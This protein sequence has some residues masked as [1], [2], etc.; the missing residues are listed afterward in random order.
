MQ[1]VGQADAA[2]AEEAAPAVAPATAA[3][4]DGAANLSASGSGFKLFVARRKESLVNMVRRSS[5]NSS[6]ENTPASS[7]LFG[8]KPS[9]E[10]ALAVADAEATLL[11]QGPV[12]VME[13]KKVGAGF[14]VFVSLTR[15][16]V[17]TMTFALTT[18]CFK[19]ADGTARVALRD[20]TAVMAGAEGFEHG[21][22]LVTNG[23]KTVLLGAE[24]AE[25]AHEWMLALAAACVAFGGSLGVLGHSLRVRL[26]AASVERYTGGILKREEI[27]EE[28][29]YRK[30]GLLV[31]QGKAGV[32][33]QWDGGSLLPAKGANYGK[34][35]FDGLVLTWH[36]PRGA[37]VGFEKKTKKKKK[38]NPKK[39]EGS[40]TSSPALTRT[41]ETATEAVVPPPP[42]FEDEPA[43]AFLFCPND[44]TYYWFDLATKEICKTDP[45]NWKWSRHFLTK[46][47]GIG[48][49]ISEGS[50]PEH[51]VMLLQMMRFCRVG[52]AQ[53]LAAT[54]EPEKDK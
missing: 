4:A 36:A 32:T 54:A 44:K 37:A 15:G 18:A 20:V 5:S 52:W 42:E 13:R 25:G 14:F 3:V 8:R 40:S 2:A 1:Q 19:C 22:S 11:K 12:T 7:P 51:V 53:A 38:R 35:V 27:D 43:M 49:W 30:S 50:C 17:K 34:G 41:P 23:E 39:G 33:Y 24:S 48:H 21:F 9:S 47:T 16:Q 45:R 29:Q 6:L 46:C 31:S 10:P 26:E 28:W